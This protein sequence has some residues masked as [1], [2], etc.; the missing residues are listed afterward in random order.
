M[1]VFIA[2]VIRT[3]RLRLSR[4]RPNIEQSPCQ[5]VVVLTM[6]YAKLKTIG[7]ERCLAG[8]HHSSFA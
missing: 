4:F 8:A 2:E 6:D 5:S 7:L 1:H 3:V